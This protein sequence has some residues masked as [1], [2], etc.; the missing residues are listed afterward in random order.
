MND[1]EKRRQRL[2]EQ[3]RELYGEK[4]SIPAIH[5]RYGAAYH[6]IYSD[7]QPQIPPSTFGIRLFLCLLLFAAFVSMDKNK[8]EV[9]NVNSSR[10]VDEI[11]TNLDV[12]EVW[13]EL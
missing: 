5:P 2:L 10:I 3:T 13:K 11:T 12:A 7:E 4:R 8:S 6:Q 9:M 1:S